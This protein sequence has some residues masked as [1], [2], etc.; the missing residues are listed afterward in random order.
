MSQSC[1]EDK[2]ENEDLKKLMNLFADKKNY[3]DEQI[4]T[5]YYAYQQLIKQSEE[6]GEPCRER[7]YIVFNALRQM[8]E[9]RNIKIT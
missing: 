5:M 9:V 2:M 4:K 3:P 6:D 7:V 1:M 8:V